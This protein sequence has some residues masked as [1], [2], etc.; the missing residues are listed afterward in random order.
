MAHT[1]ALPFNSW[2]L[3]QL[4]GML[5][6]IAIVV[7]LVE[8]L[9][10]VVLA[11]FSW[12][13]DVFPGALVDATVL[14][15]IASPIIYIWAAKPFAV[16]A[17]EAQAVVKRES[18]AKEE[19][20]RE[21]AVALAQQQSLLEQNEQ[22]RRRIQQSSVD[23]ANVS[24]MLMQRIGADLHD[25]PAQL[26]S[27][28][29][30]RLHKFLPDLSEPNDPR[31]QEL[32]DIR[33]LLE[34]SLREVR[35]ISTGLTLPEL[36]SLTLSDVCHLAIG[37][38]EERTDTSVSFSIGTLPLDASHALKVCAYRFIQEGLANAFQHAR[39]EGQRVEADV[40]NKVFCITVSDRGP[41]VDPE[42]RARRRLGLLGLRA[43]VEALGGNFELHSAQSAG[44]TLVARF[45]SEQMTLTGDH[46]V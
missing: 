15:L 26:L 46:H 8:A 4:F 37:D 19:Q 22:L 6:R 44:T 11:R 36:E 38:H 28:S 35:D 25:G 23:Y 42:W 18:A 34:T 14:T 17:H 9:I 45:A 10:M 43:R 13:S 3:R 24:E 5:V 16:A 7:F 21:L 39:A 27:L 31:K 41:G 33:A 12:M 30:L 40:T 2:E 20:R 32:A 29:L 1:R